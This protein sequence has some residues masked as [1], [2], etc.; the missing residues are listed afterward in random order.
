MARPLPG[1]CADGGRLA[2]GPTWQ[3]LHI[4]LPVTD[5]GPFSRR[6]LV[7]YFGMV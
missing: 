7:L 6:L 3:R 5:F 2:A 4:L 1:R